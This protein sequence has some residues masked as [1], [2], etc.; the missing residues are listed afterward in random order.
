MKELANV[1]YSY[2]IVSTKAP[3]QL[4]SQ[5]C[6]YSAL[7]EIK[8]HYIGEGHNKA[9]TISALRKAIQYRKE[10]RM[11]IIRSC[12]Y[13]NQ[14]YDTEE[15]RELAIKYKNYILQDLQRQPMIVLQS[16][17]I[18]AR[19]MVYKPPRTSNQNDSDEAFLITQLYTAERAIAT[20]EF[21]QKKEKLSVIFN[22]ENYS[23]K[24]SPSSSTVITLTKVLQ[25][26]YPERLGLLL[27]LSPPFWMRAFFSLIYPFMSTV[28]T[29]KIKLSTDSS[30]NELVGDDGNDELDKLIKVS[31]VSSEEEGPS[32][33]VVD[34][35]QYTQ[36]SL[37][38]LSE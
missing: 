15:D 34:I 17:D 14:Q 6:K 29:E 13:G 27:I 2:W 37:Y 5:A 22:F 8:R 20:S 21:L 1:S 25:T 28:T 9:K 3:D 32:S 12:F 23:S 38:C 18:E 36:Q 35:E 4:P 16:T 33:A 7:K 10:Y 30:L 26:C 11:D 24:N 31:S 19:V